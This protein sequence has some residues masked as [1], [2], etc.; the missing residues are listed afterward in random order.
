VCI[1]LF[2]VSFTQLDELKKE[3]DGLISQL[4][5]LRAALYK[6]FGSEAINLEYQKLLDK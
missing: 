2:S 3:R 4:D 1:D 6:K 5:E